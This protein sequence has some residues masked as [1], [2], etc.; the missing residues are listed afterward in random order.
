MES[1]SILSPRRAGFCSGR[2]ILDQILFLSLS[3]SDG[4][5]KPKLGSRTILATLDF[6]KA[7][8]FVWNPAL[9]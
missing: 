6:S 2:S 9:P 5:N 3:F 4:F 8:D 1:Y 7:F